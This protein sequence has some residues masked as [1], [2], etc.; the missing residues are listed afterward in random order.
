MVPPLL[1]RRWVLQS[2]TLLALNLLHFLLSWFHRLRSYASSASKT[3]SAYY[4][5]L[6]QE[7]SE[8]VSFIF[9]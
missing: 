3:S 9:A 7:R 5:F 2:I 6:V 1:D 4:S 8:K